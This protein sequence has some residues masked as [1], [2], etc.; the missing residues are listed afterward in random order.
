MS[1]NID[2]NNLGTFAS[3][4]AVWAAY[5]EGGQ[6]G[7]YLYIGSV[8]YRWNKYNLLWESAATYTESDA[9]KLTELY[10]DVTVNNDLHVGGTLYYHRMKGYD[11]GLFSTIASLQAAYPSPEVGMW[12]FVVHPS[13]S[14]KYQL[15]ACSTAGTW[16]LS[17]SETTLDVLDFERYEEALALMQQL[18]NGA[19]LSGYRAALSLNDLPIADPDPS[20]GWIVNNKLYV[21]VGTGGDTLDGLYKDCG[22]LRGAKG[23]K[24]DKGDNGTVIDGVSLFSDA[25]SLV[26]K[27]TAQKEEMVPDGNMIDVMEKRLVKTLPA[28]VEVFGEDELKR[29]TIKDDSYNKI[30][31]VTDN[32]VYA[33]DLSIRD[34]DVYQRLKQVPEPPTIVEK[35]AGVYVY[36]D[37]DTQIV[38]IDKTGARVSALYIWDADTQSFYRQLPS[39]NPYEGK[40]IRF[41][42]DSITKAN[43][44][45]NLGFCR[46]AVELGMTYTNGGVS[47]APTTYTGSA[48]KK[49]ISIVKRVTQ[50]TPNAYDYVIIT[51]SI[52]NDVNVT[53]GSLSNDYID[54]GSLSDYDNTTY[55]GALEIIARYITVHFQKCG[56]MIS[57][58]NGTSINYGSGNSKRSAIRA[59]CQKWGVPLLDLSECA[60]FNLISIDLRSLY[61]NTGSTPNYD[62][63]AGYSLDD[64]VIYNATKYRALEDIEAPAL[65]FDPE[66]W[67]QISESGSAADNVHCNTAAYKLMQSKIVEFIKSL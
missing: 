62:V 60:G 67:E 19:Q 5:P 27:T 46:A 56:M 6:E 25:S 54:E 22:Y 53:I 24:G 64:Q 26:G 14:G 50:L 42:G 52:V 51:P 11:L 40:T 47:G 44:D 38:K 9:R 16:T 8:K 65:A 2:I 31:E 59:V 61:G 45:S 32:G 12:A 15:Y 17:V 55:Y 29:I 39:V 3:I 43:A 20:L 66:K 63:S 10:A 21:Y 18:A 35:D 30:M 57:Y 1:K 58:K 7:D 36:D 4:A 37:D 49:A 41:D 13:I 48:S 23:D 33:K 28:K 34:V